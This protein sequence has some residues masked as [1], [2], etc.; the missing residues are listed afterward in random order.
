MVRGLGLTSGGKARLFVLVAALGAAGCAGDRGPPELLNLRAD[1]TPDEFSIQP[2][3]PLQEPADYVSL[4]PPNPGGR[5]LLDPEPEADAVAALGGRPGAVASPSGDGALLAF[6]GRY[7]VSP[8]I[9]QQLAAEDLAFRQT[10]RGRLLER[11]FNVNV[12][13][14]AYEP[15]A[16]DQEREIERFR[17]A[18]IRT[19]SPPQLTGAP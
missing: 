11:L 12:Y 16:L 18:G 7:G 1:G 8:S 5:S 14:D 15:F 19:S 13:F 3:G 17:R 10:N 9:R 2:T 6:A 4:P